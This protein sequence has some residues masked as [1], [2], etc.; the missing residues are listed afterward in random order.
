LTSSRR[1]N[2]VRA[3]RHT[4]F[5][6]TVLV[7]A[8]TALSGCG[9]GPEGE[10][11]GDTSPFGT[12][13]AD[14]STAES[15]VEL[16]NLD[17]SAL[18]PPGEARVE[19]DGNAYV[20]RASGSINFDCAAGSD[21]IR[22]NYQ[23]TD[24]GDLTFQARVVNGEWLGNITFVNG[25]DNYGGT[26]TQGGAELALGTNA[27]IYTGTMTH[28]TYSDPADTRDVEATVA[29]N[30][31][32]DGT[33][34]EATAEIDG[35]TFAFPASGAQSYECEIAPTSVTVRINRLALENKQI[36][37]QGSQPSGEWLGNVYVISGSDRYNAII[38]ADGTGLDITG[39]TLTFTGTFTH[40]SETDPSVE[41]E[42]AGSAAVAC[43]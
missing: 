24:Q 17:P 9:G 41:Q 34:A 31:G 3:A 7:A 23:Q 10:A 20:L 22:V 8:A 30:C 32:T 36:E 42:V 14:T 18:P 39:T 5:L 35:L 28:R 15:G 26:L 2:V 16:A 33:G 27:V 40:T 37:I 13:P 38:P 25:N 29:V 1:K 19:V 43:P 4:T 12:N 6:A 11:A 21:E